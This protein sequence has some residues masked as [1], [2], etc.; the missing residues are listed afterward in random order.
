MHRK[1]GKNNAHTLISNRIKIHLNN[2]LKMSDYRCS[3]GEFHMSLIQQ[4]GISRGFVKYLS[5]KQLTRTKDAEN[6][7]HELIKQ[8][9]IISDSTPTSKP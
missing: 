3:L 8:Y 1:L 6:W 5:N 9:N 4:Q 2:K 7:I